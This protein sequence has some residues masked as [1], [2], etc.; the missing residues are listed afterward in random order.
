M[1]FC[2]IFKYG[3]NLKFE[4]IVQIFWK[5]IQLNGPLSCYVYSKLHFVTI[6]NVR[7]YFG[8]GPGFLDFITSLLEGDADALAEIA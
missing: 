8:S 2:N 7:L 6:E 4:T 1:K 5:I 3:M